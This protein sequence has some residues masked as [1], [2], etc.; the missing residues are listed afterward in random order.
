M[1]IAGTAG[2]KGTSKNSNFRHRMTRSLSRS[3]RTFQSATGFCSA[4]SSWNCIFPVSRWIA[5]TPAVPHGARPHTSAFFRRPSP[6]YRWIFQVRFDDPTLTFPP[7]IPIV[8]HCVTADEFVP[9][10]DGNIVL[11]AVLR[12]PVFLRPARVAILLAPFRRMVFRALRYV[13]GLYRLVFLARVPILPHRN[14]RRADDFPT[15]RQIWPLPVTECP[16][17]TPS[18]ETEY[19]P[20]LRSSSHGC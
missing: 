11:I 4:R 5:H 9:P 6:V 16:E 10:V 20:T 17:A 18:P 19:F 14:D 13:S 8:R 3:P 2:L 12:A 7:A 15:H 1:K